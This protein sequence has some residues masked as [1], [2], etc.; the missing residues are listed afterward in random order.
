MIVI[1][2]ISFCRFGTFVY[3]LLCALTFAMAP[4]KRRL[5]FWA[6]A[7]TIINLHLGLVSESIHFVDRAYSGFLPSL[8][9]CHLS[10][11]SSLLSALYIERS[12]TM[13]FAFFVTLTLLL[14][15]RV[16]AMT[17][18]GAKCS[19]N[20]NG[21][22]S[23]VAVTCGTGESC[24]Q[25]ATCTLRADRTA[26]TTRGAMCLGPSQAARIGL[27]NRVRQAR[28]TKLAVIYALEKENK[29]RNPQTAKREVAPVEVP[30]WR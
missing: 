16:H 12:T 6:V 9:F 27:S 8:L 15:T 5:T 10:V 25:L 11:S 29:S 1:Q 14:C 23:C 2:A 19:R 4:S 13:R 28:N 17:M 22:F 21:L 20:E 3:I 7:S 18:C 26:C 24:A 30:M